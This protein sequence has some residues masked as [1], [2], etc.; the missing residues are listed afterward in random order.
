MSPR[1]GIA[2][3]FRYASVG[4]EPVICFAI[5]LVAGIYAD[6]WW[7]PE[8]RWTIV[9]AIVGFVASVYRL[10][11]ISRQYFKGGGGEKPK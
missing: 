10:V 7:G 3:V 8:P 9:G 5:C 2:D 6:R 1:P 11:A 4:L